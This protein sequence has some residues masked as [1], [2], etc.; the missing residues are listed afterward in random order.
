MSGEVKLDFQ[1][2]IAGLTLRNPIVLASGTFGYGSEVAPCFEGMRLDELGGISLKGIFW[3]PRRGNPTPRVVETSA[4]M[5]NAI[6][7]EGVGAEAMVH[8]VLPSL[9]PKP[10]ALFINV[11]GTS[12]DEYVKIV[13]YLDEQA[14]EL[15]DAIELNISC[16]NLSCGGLEFG[17]TPEAAR[18]VTEA[19]IE[20]AGE[21]PVYVKLAP[22]VANLPAIALAVAE[23]G[24][25]GLSLINTYPGMAVDLE[26]RRPVL[27]KTYGGLSGPA[28]KPLALRAVHLVSKAL[29]DTGR[30]DVSI[31][32]MGGIASGRDALEFLVAGASSVSLGTVNFTRPFAYRDVL[33]EME[34][35]MRARYE[36]TKDPRDLTVGGWSGALHS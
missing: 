8:D 30:S 13:R 23:A 11:C 16:P 27:A 24:A 26:N 6:G 17:V 4:G 10:C 7:L 3:E 14:P 34:T 18:E 28:I 15:W 25:R 31:V 36:R 32:G 5:L 9:Q 20:A 21:H 12:V 19:S 29:R 1:T 33:R 35:L 2:R 22:M